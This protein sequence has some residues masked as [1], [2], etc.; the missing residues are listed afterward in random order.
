MWNMTRAR[1]CNIVVQFPSRTFINGL[2][3]SVPPPPTPA[4]IAPGHGTNLAHP[5]SPA[6][7]QDYPAAQA[8]PNL[9]PVSVPA[10]PFAQPPHH[11]SAPRPRT[12]VT[13]PGSPSIYQTK[14]MTGTKNTH[15]RQSGSVSVTAPREGVKPKPGDI[16]THWN[17]TARESQAWLCRSESWTDITQDFKVN[18]KIN[19]PDESQGRILV[20]K[21][22]PSGRELNWLT[23]K[24]LETWSWG[25]WEKPGWAST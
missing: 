1:K 11:A 19:H 24:W 17:T 25:N 9:T 21:G 18:A 6:Q 8:P 20:M 16:F 22:D 4:S 14:T 15:Y 10:A 23:L 7:A 3:T 13:S 2:S 5:P 12:Q